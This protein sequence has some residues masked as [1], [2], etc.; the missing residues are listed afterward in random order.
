MDLA[1]R[2]E[3]LLIV[4]AALALILFLCNFGIVGTAGNIVSDVMFGIFGLTAYIAPVIIF[5]MIAFGMSNIG[6]RIAN[7]KLV[8]G[9]ILHWR[10]VISF[11]RFISDAVNSIAAAEFWQDLW[12]ICPAT[13]WVW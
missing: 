9:P 1:I 4:L 12:H 6:S 5:L 3:I 11:R 7:R 8:A 2:N 10:R 13:S